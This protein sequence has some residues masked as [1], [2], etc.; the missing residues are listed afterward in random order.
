M[1]HPDSLDLRAQVLRLLNRDEEA[2]VYER[3][4]YGTQ[5]EQLCVKALALKKEGK[6]TEAKTTCKEA[7]YLPSGISDY[8]ALKSYAEIAL[9]HENYKSAARFGLQF[10]LLFEAHVHEVLPIF[11]SGTQGY[12]QMLL[13]QGEVETAEKFLT[14][15]LAILSLK[16]HPEILREQAK[17]LR[18]KGKIFESIAL[19]QKANRLE[20]PLAKKK[21]KVEFTGS[22]KKTGSKTGSDLAF[23]HSQQGTHL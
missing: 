13:D 3:K 19:E 14:K 7:L 10:I 2:L 16:E 6:L 15:A 22:I 11:I 4:V 20:D 12:V 23:G 9:A 18:K 1:E 8:H 5:I 17:V 21:S